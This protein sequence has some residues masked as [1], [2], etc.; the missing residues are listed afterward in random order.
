MVKCRKTRKESSTGKMNK[1][2][3]RMM[4]QK[5]LLPRAR[6]NNKLPC[7]M[8]KKMPSPRTPIRKKKVMERKIT[9][10]GTT[11]KSK[12]LRVRTKTIFKKTS[13]CSSGNEKVTRPKAS[14]RD[15]EVR[16]HRGNS[17]HGESQIRRIAPAGDSSAIPAAEIAGDVHRSIVEHFPLEAGR[18]R[19]LEI[20]YDTGI[21]TIEFGPPGSRLRLE[22]EANILL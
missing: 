13:L 10:S 5:T 15:C 17:Q 8:T 14:S 16:Q 20:N 7:R 12:L 1:S 21:S 22:T 6:M 11:N 19:I 9:S 4:T 3:A 18:L 2:S